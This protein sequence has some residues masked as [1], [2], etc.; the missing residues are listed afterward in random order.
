MP[1]MADITVKKADG[2]TDVVYVAATPSSGDKNAAIWTQNAYSGVQG[3]RPRLELATMNNGN[4]T[5]RQMRYRYSFPVVYTDSTTSLQKLLGSMVSEG[6]VHLPK[7]ISTV[8][9]KESFAQL[10]NLL[11]SSLLRQV[12][13]TGFSPT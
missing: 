9:W 3:F 8:E 4:G 7:D 2:T 1:N 5:T 13:E 10:G 6:V 11:S 12:A